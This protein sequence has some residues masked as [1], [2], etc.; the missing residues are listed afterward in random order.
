MVTVLDKFKLDSQ[1]AL[2]TGASEGIGEAIATGLAQAGAHVYINSRD[3]RRVAA[4]VERLAADGHRV[5][6]LP[7]DAGNE[8][9]INRAIDDIKA[10]EGRLDI[11]V[12]NVGMRHRYPLEQTSGD[13]FR[14]VLEVNLTATYLI[15]KRAAGLMVARG[16]G[17]I[18]MIGSIAGI[19]AY[20]STVAYASSKAGMIGLTKVLAMEYG[21]YGVTCNMIAPGPV[22]TPINQ[23]SLASSEHYQRGALKRAAESVELAGPALLLVS[24]ASSFITG[25]ILAVDGGLTAAM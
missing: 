1:V 9:A 7:F 24:P 4:V 20:K 11:L 23:A 13:D 6:G 16:Y 15:S 18:L 14:K 17:R 8:E 10:A 12:N 3:P 19:R 21:E 25:Q 5:S 22:L 2:V